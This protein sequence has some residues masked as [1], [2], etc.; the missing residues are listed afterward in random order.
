MEVA[1]VTRKDM[2]ESLLAGEFRLEPSGQRWG[3]DPVIVGVGWWASARSATSATSIR[4][5]IASP[6]SPESN[7]RFILDPRDAELKQ[8]RVALVVRRDLRWTQATRL[9]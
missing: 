6:D 7:G 3:I 5:V 1:L 4:T 2:E 9:P 8:P